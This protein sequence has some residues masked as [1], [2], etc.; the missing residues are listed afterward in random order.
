MQ[1]YLFVSLFLGHDKAAATQRLLRE[2]NLLDVALADRRNVWRGELQP[3]VYIRL[4]S[5]DE[6]LQK[7][8]AKLR[9]R[10]VVP[11]TR[12]DR[13]YSEEELNRADLLILR[14]AT[15]GLLGGVDY[16]QTYD[17]AK[18]CETC[19]AG[20]VPNLPLI[21]D[22]GSMGKKDIDHLICEG[23]LV[24]SKRLA[25]AMRKMTGVSVQPVRSPRRASS[26]F[27]WLRITNQLPRMHSSTRG[28]ITEAQCPVCGR[29]GHYGTMSEPESVSYTKTQNAC[30][31]NLTW[32]SFGDWK[33]QRNKTPHRPVGGKQG[34]VVS[35]RLRQ[36]FLR[37]KV[38]RL[39]WVPVTISTIA[40]VALTQHC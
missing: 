13:E 17:S 19:G 23:H 10:G 16:S 20:S 2:C 8:L 12:I 28:Y 32:E 9:S 11:F 30:D 22:L 33:Q 4:P 6:R 31:F 27:F 34:I 7:L 36:E 38:R 14:I 40:T 18:A 1:D 24:V 5:D 26:Q 3:G 25:E 21:A 29:A 35:Q 15:A 39:V 37:L